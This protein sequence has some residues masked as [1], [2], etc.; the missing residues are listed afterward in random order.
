MQKESGKRYCVYARVSTE[1]QAEKDLSIPFQLERCRYHAQGK[2]GEVVKEFV[3]AGESARTDKRPEFQKMIDAARNKEFD[4]ILVHKFDRF[5]RNDYDFVVYEKLLEDLGIVVES[6][7]EPGD[8]STPA[9][10]IGRRMM[11]V[12]STWYS[13]NLAIEV[14]KGMYKKVENGG[15]PK[16]APFGYLNKHDKNSAWVEVDP[17]RGPVVTQ[18]FEAMATDGWTLSEWTEQAYALGYRSRN[19]L[20]IGKSAWG[21]IFH[22][23]FYLGETWIK[24]GDVPIK[25][26]HPP[27]VK[28]DIFTKVQEILRQHDKHKQR[29]H[30][31]K[32]L[33]RGLVYSEDAGSPCWAETHIEKKASYYRSRAKSNGSNVF[34]NARDIEQQLP[35]YIHKVA[36]TEEQRQE[37]RKELAKMFEDEAATNEEL[38]QAEAR[39]SKLEKMEKNLQQLAIEE[40]ISFAD[41]KEHRTRIESERARLNVTVDA[42]KQRQ[43][44]VKADFEIALD[45]AT[46]LNFFY[47]KGGFDERRLLCEVI[48][49]RINVKDGKI[50]SVDLNAPFR[51]IASKASGSGTVV[52]GGAEGIRTPDLLLA[53][54][55]NFILYL[56]LY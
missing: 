44:L 9:G 31:H 32:Y 53:R 54:L 29:T 42:I 3:D 5:A 1:E 22:N 20:K 6:V 48:F 50:A 38:K 49:K 55:K 36:I 11:Q 37:M 26:V 40:E 15:W 25:G 14:K 33:L 23:R 46:K 12:I 27:L 2:G 13:K 35:D 4:V 10:Y 52:Y 47:E 41:F 51:L 7:S 30:R 18:A 17:E 8:A 24:K 34:Y 43:H 21:D 45:L 19:G 16:K 39:L 56:Q 28:E